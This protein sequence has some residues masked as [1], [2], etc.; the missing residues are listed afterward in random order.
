VT[1]NE[2]GAPSVLLHDRAN[3]IAEALGIGTLHLSLTHTD[4][5]AAAFVVGSSRDELRGG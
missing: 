3:E 4:H 1:L 5:L 2:A